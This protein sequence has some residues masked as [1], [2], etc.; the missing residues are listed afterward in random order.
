M[1]LK[2]PPPI[3]AALFALT[4]WGM[5]TIATFAALTIH[6]SWVVSLVLLVVALA[7]DF[8]ALISFQIAKT[9][10]N[11]MQ[12]HK[13][14]QLVVVGI[15]KFTRNPMY[16]GLAVIMLAFVIWFG[17]LINI[18][19]LFTFVWY[20]TQYQIIPEERALVKLF[21]DDFIAYQSSVR[22]WI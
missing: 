15:Y 16:L 11:P 20:I 17:N 7:I 12:P 6:V 19:L 18:A 4:M 13:A 1:E 10:I 5:A 3:V 14:S 21:G 9:T 8:F 22:R 2:I